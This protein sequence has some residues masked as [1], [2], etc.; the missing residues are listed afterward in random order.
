MN[1]HLKYEWKLPGQWECIIGKREK[2]VVCGI[3]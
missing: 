3:S 2:Y 1:C